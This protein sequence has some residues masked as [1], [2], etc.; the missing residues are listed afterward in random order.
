MTYRE[1]SEREKLQW[2]VKQRFQL[3][4]PNA[5]HRHTHTHTHT[6]GL[7]NMHSSSPHRVPSD[8]TG[9]NTEMEILSVQGHFCG[10]RGPE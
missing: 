8:G 2:T 4:P 7:D 6:D 10:V 5:A 1:P 3:I 9:L